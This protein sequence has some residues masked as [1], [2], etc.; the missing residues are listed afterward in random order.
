MGVGAER[1][2]ENLHNIV[3]IE[4]ARHRGLISD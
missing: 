1:L 4:L 3:D 2:S